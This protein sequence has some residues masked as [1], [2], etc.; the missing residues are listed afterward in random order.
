MTLLERINK[1]LAE[2]DGIGADDAGQYHTAFAVA[3]NSICKAE[4]LSLSAWSINHQGVILFHYGDASRG[5]RFSP[6]PIS[7]ARAVPLDHVW[8]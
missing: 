3:L 4:G 7:G 8:H 2:L 1:R 5:G 6:G